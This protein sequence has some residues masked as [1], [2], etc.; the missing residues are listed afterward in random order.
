MDQGVRRL[1]TLGQVQGCRRLEGS[2]RQAR[3]SPASP[4]ITQE[5]RNDRAATA[6][7]VLPQPLSTRPDPS[8]GAQ[9]RPAQGKSPAQQLF[10]A[11]RF[12]HGSRCR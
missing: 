1:H 10:P 4:G 12:T 11:K 9:G 6:C 3:S 7:P 5:G 2:F 8:W